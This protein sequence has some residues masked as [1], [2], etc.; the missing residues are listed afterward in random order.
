[1]SADNENLQGK[2]VILGLSGGVD[3]A[4]AAILLQQLGADVHA[5]HMTNW[6]DDDGYCTAAADLQDARQI[7]EQ[8][9]I[10]LHHINF[11]REYRDRVFSY[12]LEEYKRGRTPNPDVL[13]NREIKFGAFR[14]HAKRLGGDLLATGH[15][16]RTRVVNDNVQLLK[17]LDLSKDQSYFLHAVSADALSETVFPLG[18]LQKFA[19]RDIAREHA[20]PVF[21]KKDST[22]ICFI[23]ERPFREFLSTYLP[24]NPGPIKTDD[25]RIIGEHRGLMFYTLGQR[26]GLGIGGR[27]DAGDEPWYVAAKDLQDN[28]LTVVQGDHPLR[29]SSALEATDCSWIGE[30]PVALADGQE[31]SCNAKIRYRQDDQQCTLV[32]GEQDRLLVTFSALQTAVAPGQ[33]VVFY[34]GDQCLGGAIIDRNISADESLRK[35]G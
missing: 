12:F 22:G 4:V 24:A 13:C 9:G 17:A 5:L 30:A 11:A 25:G 21:D 1:M 33:F 35:T 14:E 26:Q 23:G 31:F 10:P 28:V 6:E 18:E 20:L 29:Y 7:C 8:L 34:A 32:R 3:S 16:A 19:V 2:R 27:R 15:Y